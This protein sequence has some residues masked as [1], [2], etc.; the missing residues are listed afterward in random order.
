MYTPPEIGNLDLAMNSYQY[1]LWLDV[2]MH[3]MFL[4]QVF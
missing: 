4:M 2:P 1:I 3:D